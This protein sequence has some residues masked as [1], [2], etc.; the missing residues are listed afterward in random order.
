MSHPL[1]DK[2]RATLDGALQAIHTREY[3]SPYGEHPSPRNYG[4][5]SDVAGKAAFDALLGQ[6]FELDQPAVQGWYEQETSPYGA[7]L[8]VSYPVCDPDAL[9]AAAQAA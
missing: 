6:R 2:H 1:L 9:I 8:N 4:E 7:A 5:V 3:W